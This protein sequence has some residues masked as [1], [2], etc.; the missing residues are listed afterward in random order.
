MFLLDTN[1]ISELRKSGTD[2]I[3][4][5]VNAWAQAVAADELY[6]SVISLAEL[7]MG[8]LALERKDPAQ[9][10]H[11]RVWLEQYVK[12]HFRQRILHVTDTVALHYARMNVPDRLPVMDG[13]IAATA[14][15]HNM[16]VVT[17]NTA[18]FS[19]VASLN[20]FGD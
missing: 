7:E 19:C 14:L 4:A 10:V 3:D 15:V 2:R 9:A 16:I 18:D 12:V 13:L 20:P 11:L 6:L 17:R 5:G 8:V 1:V